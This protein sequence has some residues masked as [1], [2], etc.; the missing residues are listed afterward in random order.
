MTGQ[1]VFLIHFA[2]SFIMMGAMW[3]VQVA[4]YPNLQYVGGPEF[5]RYQQEHIRRVSTVAWTMLVVELATAV[6]L[7]FFPGSLER[8]GALAAN[9]FLL[10]VIWWST[11]RVQVPL[12][13]VLEQGFD[14]AAHRQLVQTNWVRTV[15]YSLRGAL[16]LTLM[17]NDLAARRVVL[18]E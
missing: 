8:R 15:C 3:F 9:L 11:W 13:K 14:A 17:L 5:I 2:A 7:P 6:V 1:V 12:H 10:S 4:Y 18:P 16:L